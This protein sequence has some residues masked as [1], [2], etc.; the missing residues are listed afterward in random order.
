M[1]KKKRI[2]ILI[3]VFVFAL[4]M[5]INLSISNN[6]ANESSINVTLS[7]IVALAQSG[8]EEDE[9]GCGECWQNGY[10]KWGA[11]GN[12]GFLTCN[13]DVISLGTPKEECQ[14]E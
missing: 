8:G 14:C 12:Q 9:Q 5:A 7:S 3:S 6:Y 13:C 10:K 4:L 2:L 1:M 11:A